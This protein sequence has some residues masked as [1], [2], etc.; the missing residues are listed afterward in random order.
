[1]FYSQELKIKFSHFSKQFCGSAKLGFCARKLYS[2]EIIFKVRFKQHQIV[3][4][5]QRTGR[6]VEAGRTRQAL[7]LVGR[8]SEAS[9]RTLHARSLQ[10]VPDAGVGYVQGL[11]PDV[12]VEGLGS[13]GR[14]VV[15]VFALFRRRSSVQAKVT[16]LHF[17]F[18]TGFVR[19]S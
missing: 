8:I 5:V 3:S 4:N 16:C 7:A 17:G 6:A 19:K 12:A 13:A 10:G 18:Y 14:A 1:M 15:R 2:S 11:V 9:R